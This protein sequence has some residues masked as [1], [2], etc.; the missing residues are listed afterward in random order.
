MPWA[1]RL[2]AFQAVHAE[3]AKLENAYIQSSRIAN[4]T[5]RENCT[6]SAGVCKKNA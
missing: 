5:E 1:G 3:I 6:L 4:P 2:L